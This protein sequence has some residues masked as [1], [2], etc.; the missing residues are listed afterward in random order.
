MKRLALF[1]LLL[2]TS[3]LAF[4]TIYSYT[5]KDGKVYYTNERPTGLTTAERAKFIAVPTTAWDKLTA[6][7]PNKKKETDDRVEV[8]KIVKKD[9]A[10]VV[11]PP[12][13]PPPPVV[14]NPV[15]VPTPDKPASAV[16]CGWEG[17]RCNVPSGITARVFIGLGSSWAYKD[18]QTGAV[19]C[20]KANLGDPKNGSNNNDCWFVDNKE[21]LTV[22]DPQGKNLMPYVN[23]ALTP[24]GDAGF[25]VP[26]IKPTT[27]IPPADTAGAFRISCNYSHGNF[28]DPIVW[29][30]LVGASHHH[31]FFGNTSITANSTSEGILKEGNSTCAGGILNRSGYWM[32]SLIDTANGAPQKPS[33][34][35]V[36]YKSADAK[37]GAFIQAPPKGLRM[38]AGNA[39]PLA[40]TQAEGAFECHDI[41][42]AM[43]PA[44]WGIL[45]KGN[46]IKQSCGG[47]NQYLRMI[48]S[49][50]QCWDG[51]NLDSPDHKSHMAFA[52]GR[53]C[54][55]ADGKLYDSPNSC[56]V[57]H[58]V[59]IPSIAINADFYG[60]DSNAKYRLSSDNY[61][62]T[63][64]G[65]YSLHA[66]WMNGWDEGTITR[67]VKNCL[68]NPKNCGGPNLGDGQTLYG[69]NQD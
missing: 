65:G 2:A 38:I 66:D 40:I 56:P 62:T 23:G 6:A 20:T 36:Y 46:N 4:A 48:V 24:K 5:A 12:P 33:V 41:A 59:A 7:S 43:N 16:H 39:R 54:K 25:S 10:P 57:S 68:N 29:P 51:K 45:W 13:P 17:G 21:L 42:Q 50:P 9:S 11:T 14:T 61:S 31:T 27:V 63:Y 67:M 15:L 52:C 37:N 47:S 18:N 28:D 22:L 30:N 55:G 58:P 69:V 19:A 26:M 32:P 1:V 3:V 44:N 34:V 64:P 49:F 8:G 53:N 60:L 35:I